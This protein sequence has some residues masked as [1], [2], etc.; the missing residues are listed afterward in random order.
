MERLK[1]IMINEILS[2]S[3]QQNDGN[4]NQQQQQQHSQIDSGS[5]HHNLSAAAAA[6]KAAAGGGH[7]GSNAI[8]QELK[9]QDIHVAAGGG[10]VGSGGNSASGTTKKYHCDICGIPLSA[11]GSIKRHKDAVH[12]G[13]RKKFVER[14]CPVCHKSYFQ[15][16]KHIKIKHKECKVKCGICDRVLSCSFSYKRHLKKVHGYY[17]NNSSEYS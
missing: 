8:K 1:N 7:Q 15:L 16:Q 11:F 13:I 14:E 17:K 3:Y 12:Y 5:S 10:S 6:I 9:W 2:N 4:V